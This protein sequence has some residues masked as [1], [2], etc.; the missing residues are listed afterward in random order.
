MWNTVGHIF[1]K[2]YK[3]KPRTIIWDFSITYKHRI[4]ETS[5]KNNF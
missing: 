2:L 1:P 3:Y 4:N 5:I